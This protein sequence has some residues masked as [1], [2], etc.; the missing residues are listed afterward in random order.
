MSDVSQTMADREQQLAE[1]IASALR[2]RQLARRAAGL[3]D[4]TPEDVR[5]IIE[6]ALAAAEVVTRWTATTVDDTVVAVL[7]QLA[8]SEALDRLIALIL[9]LLD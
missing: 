1:A 4:V 7:K 3:P 9:A 8:Q 2:P 5:T 6:A